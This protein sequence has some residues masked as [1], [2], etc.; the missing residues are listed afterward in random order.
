M[1]I[2]QR[3][4]L[5]LKVPI[6][7]PRPH[8]TDL[9]TDMH[10]KGCMSSIRLEIPWEPQALLHSPLAG[11]LGPGTESGTCWALCECLSSHSPFPT[12][13]PIQSHLQEKTRGVSQSFWLFTTKFI[14]KNLN[15][16]S[17]V[18]RLRPNG[19]SQVHLL[20]GKENHHMQAKKTQRQFYLKG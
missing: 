17:P 8:G 12:P 14:R 1:P 13:W 3:R 4:K 7:Y 6:T 20:K 19:I 18:Y 11:K 2:L 5:R 15:A 10:S 9:L 16:P